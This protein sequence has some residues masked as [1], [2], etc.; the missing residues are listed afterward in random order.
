MYVKTGTS[1]VKRLYFVLIAFFDFSELIS[2]FG[3]LSSQSL[4]L[5]VK[6]RGIFPSSPDLLEIVNLAAS[7]TQSFLLLWHDSTLFKGLGCK[8]V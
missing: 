4:V 8:T 5:I 6:I 2:K 7:G 1:L 3:S